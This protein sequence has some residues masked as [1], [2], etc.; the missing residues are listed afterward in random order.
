MFVLCGFNKVRL[1]QRL[2]GTDC[3][4][5]FDFY[6]EPI[7]NPGT[8]VRGHRPRLNPAEDPA[9]LTFL[10][11]VSKFLPLSGPQQRA[12]GNEGVGLDNP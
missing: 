3:C 6:G 7:R 1:F 11:T 12:L 4:D 2:E 10:V 9:S 5:C 8:L